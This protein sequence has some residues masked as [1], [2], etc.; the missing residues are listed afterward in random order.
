ML[1]QVVLVGRVAKIPNIIEENNKR[2]LE[3][4]IS[5][6][7]NY[8]NENGIY[9]TD[10]INCIIYDEMARN[11]KEFTKIGDIIGIKGR[12]QNINNIPNIITDKIVLYRGKDETIEDIKYLNVE[13]FLSRLS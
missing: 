9:E 7:R 8:K 11:T 3:L 4:T 10:F 2:I 6:Q 1:N 5:V 12:V 13:Q